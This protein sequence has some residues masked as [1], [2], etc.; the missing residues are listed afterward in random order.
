MPTPEEL[1]GM[2][3]PVNPGMQVPVDPSPLPQDMAGMPANTGMVLPSE[4][5]QELMASPEP[6]MQEFEALGAMKNMDPNLLTPEELEALSGSDEETV[7]VDHYK[8][9]A[10]DMDE[11]ELGVIAQ[12]LIALVQ[13]DE[14]SRDDWYRRVQKGIRNLGVSEKTFG[15]A[16]FDGASTVVH[17]V[18][19]E[20]C[21][22]FQ[23]RAI[24]EMWPSSGPV[25]TQV[26]GE[27]TPEKQDQAERV[28]NYMNYMYTVQMTEA[29]NQEDNMLLRL[30]IS[31]STFKKMYYDP[32]KKRLA[33]LFVEPADFIVSYQTTDLMSSPR[34]TH[35]IREYQN[36]VR[37][38]EASGFYIKNNKGYRHSE[39]TDKPF[40]IDE[41]DLTEGKER[42]TNYSS[43]ETED[44]ATMYEIYVD[45]NVETRSDN[46]SSKGGKSKGGKGNTGKLDD[47]A[48]L[49]PYIITVDRDQQI[50]KRIQRNWKPDDEL[51]TK[52]LYFAHYKFTPGL[53]FYGY[54][55]LHLIGDMAATATGALR[56]L[57]DSAAFS[58]LQ[59]G[60]RTRHSRIPGD[61]KPLSPGEWREVDSTAEELK[62]AFFHIPYKEPSPTLFNLLGYVDDKARHLAGI[63][64]TTTGEASP[65]NAPVGTTAMLLEQGTKVFTSIH[66]RMH[67][68]HKLE[69]K[70]MAELIEEYMPDE[71]Y[72]YL[73][74][75]QE[76]T[77]MPED[78]DKRIDVLPVSDPNISSNAQRVAKAQS[79]LE[80]QQTYPQVIN[81]REAVKRMLDA[82]QVQNVDGLI[83]D[84]QQQAQKDEEAAAKQEEME[85]LEKERIAIETD[86][87][88]A[89][90]K[91]II[92]KAVRD[93]LEAIQSAFEAA[94]L[95]STSTDLIPM[96]DALLQSAGFI[97]EN[98][99]S[100]IPDD[101]MPQQTMPLDPG[102]PGP[103]DRMMLPEQY[104][105][106][107]QQAV[108]QTD[109]RALADPGMQGA[110]MAPPPVQEA[111]MP[112]PQE[113]FM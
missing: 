62:D 52:R 78:F 5:P 60:F 101:M 93:N 91:Q 14:D 92:A 83:G 82:I 57:L 54:G 6:S 77:L 39:D 86:K 1:A 100:L 95:A 48:I 63:T 56:A 27:Q 94:A 98:P 70:I 96:S 107:I 41:I 74:G 97:D 15:G 33:S 50:V 111:P 30:P 68:A 103:D 26:L 102:L 104:D 69:F 53:G 18:L 37:K 89:E 22:Q 59:G 4:N 106:A 67:E 85:A 55:F 65:K 49:K 21:T 10:K 28:Q 31:G 23:S 112:P 36:D 51:E 7:D 19:M 75:T 43:S 64:E 90:V 38:K 76:G 16:N 84:D 108:G 72:P 79:I 88:K 113:G 105:E 13:A 109:Q 42:T 11:N 40:I 44:R 29:F 99:D 71:G 46:N 17:P 35:R 8:N 20:A 81:E 24:Q 61:S 32:L 34:F 9:L 110:P 73:L 80:L 87:L 3:V 45:Y 25:Q 12:D 47:E 2:Q 66:K 58:N